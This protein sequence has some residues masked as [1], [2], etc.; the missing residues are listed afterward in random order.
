MESIMNRHTKRSLLDQLDKEIG[1]TPL[2]KLNSLS[3]Q[4]IQIFAKVEW[5]QFGGSIKSRPAYGIMK[6]AILDGQLHKKTLLDASSGNTG[7]AYAAIGQ[8]LGIPV[9]I[10][11]PENASQQR[12]DL[13]NHYG[14]EIIYTSPLEG[15]DG[16]QIRAYE[17]FKSYPDRYFYADQY[18]N[19]NN[20]LAHFYSTGYEIWSQTAH[21][22]THFVTA[23][24]TTGT[25]L[26]VKRRLHSHNPNI[27]CIALQPDSPLHI[28]EGWKHLA[29]AKTPRIFQQNEVDEVITIDSDDVF[30]MIQSI[31][32]NEGIKIS[33]SAAGNL[34]GAVD[35]SQRIKKGCIVTI[36]PDDLSK[37]LDI[38]K[39]IFS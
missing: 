4:D 38:E 29:T 5:Q 13:L 37:Y 39:S 15:T 27:K 2:I 20:W 31:Y 28:L 16:A 21:L 19:E 3:S 33:P 14:A 1:R 11:L 18:G 36:L 12:K 30:S 35:V 25:Y 26:G 24:G 34:L 9:T 6:Q 23:L 10:C 8:R 22:I 32:E 17:L 7:I